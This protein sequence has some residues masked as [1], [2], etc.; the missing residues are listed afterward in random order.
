MMFTPVAGHHASCA[1]GGAEQLTEQMSR[2]VVCG[3]ETKHQNPSCVWSSGPGL[4]QIPNSGICPMTASCL[5]TTQ[6]WQKYPHSVLKLKYGYGQGSP[7][8]LL[9]FDC[10]RR[11]R[12]SQTRCETKKC[13]RCLLRR[14]MPLCIPSALIALPRCAPC[15][16][17]SSARLANLQR[18]D[19]AGSRRCQRPLISMEP[20]ELHKLT[21]L[22]PKPT[23]AACSVYFLFFLTLYPQT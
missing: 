20:V 8:V 14:L 2:R 3:A 18:C 6:R 17:H 9:V 16:L 23:T 1:C 5:A 22:A 4:C 10:S 12:T 7:G 11:R 19:P 13:H 15:I 21:L